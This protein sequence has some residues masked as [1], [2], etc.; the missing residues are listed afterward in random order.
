MTKRAAGGVLED[1]WLLVERLP[2]VWRAL[3]AGA[4]DAARA[5]VM[6]HE[7]RALAEPFA[8]RVAAQVLPQ[9][10]ELTTGQLAY[11][12]RRLVL[13]TDPDAAKDNYILRV[14]ER[15][16]VAGTNPDGTAYL[17]GCSLP[18]GQAA[19][20]YERVN[21]IA[22]ATKQSGDSRPMDQ[23]RTDVYLGL[24]EGTWNGPG[25]VH[26]RGVIELTAD[27]PTLLNLAD[28]PA[29]LHGWGPV[30]ADIARQITHQ[31]TTQPAAGNTAWAYSITEPRTGRLLYHGTTR[32]RPTH[33]SPPGSGTAAHSNSATAGPAT[34]NRPGA[35]DEAGGKA[36][37]TGR[38]GSGAGGEGSG[39]GGRA[40][41]KAV[42]LDRAGSGAGGRATGTGGRAENRASVKDQAKSGTEG[43]DT[44]TGGAVHPVTAAGPGKRVAPSERDPRRTLTAR[45][46]AYVIAR[47]RTCRGPGCRVPARRAEIDHIVPH[48]DGGPSTPDNADA[49]C[50]YCHDLKDG[51][52]TTTRTPRGVTVWTSPLGHTY[53]KLPEP[54]TRPADLT[55][56]EQRLATNLDQLP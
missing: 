10:P 34:G 17:S 49:K 47:D 2:A 37:A 7:T 39:A 40:G 28:N 33:L 38:A 15:R 12:L 13:E 4:I 5:K 25:P 1:A 3:R 52:W 41:G 48:A 50:A 53:T 22:R 14:A 30:I 26:R 6:V 11:R 8:R 19:A 21:A 29:E 16:V 43:R 42:A 45:D 51:G 18:V 31:A 55:P 46:R 32:R 27:L 24:L 35:G 56:A 44:G 9:A 23:I 20:A 36:V 54:V